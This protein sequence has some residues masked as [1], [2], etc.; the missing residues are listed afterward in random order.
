MVYCIEIKIDEGIPGKHIQIK[1]FEP[2][3]EDTVEVKE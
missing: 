2:S 3:I 1:S